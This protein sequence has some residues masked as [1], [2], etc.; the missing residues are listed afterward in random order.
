MHTDIWRV[1]GNPAAT[2]VLP[3]LCW[4]RA[5]S[6]SLPNDPN[7]MENNA[8]FADER[9]GLQG[10]AC[11]IGANV[12][13]HNVIVCSDVSISA[14]VTIFNRNRLQPA[15]LSEEDIV[16]QNGV[17]I[18]LEGTV[19]QDWFLLQSL[20]SIKTLEPSR[21]LHERLGVLSSQGW[22]T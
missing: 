17:V 10:H 2:V 1:A 14:S 13:L 4:V 16:I 5:G 3:M 18:V 21:E 7:V 9:A 15:D 22:F 20:Q 19:I 8:G 11:G 6:I 12:V